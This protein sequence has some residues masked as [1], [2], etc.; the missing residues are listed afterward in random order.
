M[1]NVRIGSW[2]MEASKPKCFINK[3]NQELRELVMHSG[4]ISTL[5]LE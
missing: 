4:F 2:L 3:G 5:D 1:F